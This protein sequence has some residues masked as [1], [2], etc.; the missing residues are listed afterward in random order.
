MESKKVTRKVVTKT[1]APSVSKS[2]SKEDLLLEWVKA[3]I[4]AKSCL[5]GGKNPDEKQKARAK[6]AEIEAKINKL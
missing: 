5:G 4:H 2:Q 6:L 1:K 3:H